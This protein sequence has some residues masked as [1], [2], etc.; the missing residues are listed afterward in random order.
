MLCIDTHPPAF[1][2]RAVGILEGRLQLNPTEGEKSFVLLTD[3]GASIPGGVH[4]RAAEAIISNPMLLATTVRILVYPRT[5]KNFLEVIAVDIEEVGSTSSKQKDMFLIQGFNLGTRSPGK[6]Q[7]GIRP[8]KRSKHQFEKFWL[9]L[10]GHLTQDMRCV[11]QLK[12]LR[13]GR[14]LFI[15]ESDPI[16]PKRCSTSERNHPKRSTDPRHVKSAA[17]ISS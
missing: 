8:N 17:V 11:Y 7:I 1:C 13:K 2:S 16:L 14:K 3:D 4:G 9:T 12:A 6:S 15:L 10:F 5:T